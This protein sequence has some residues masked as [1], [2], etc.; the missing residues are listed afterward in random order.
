MTT[1]DISVTLP[2]STVYVS[3]T[4]N[5]VDKTFTLT[6]TLDSSTIWTAEVDRV[7]SD[8]YVCSITA[9]SSNGS[10]T[11]IETTLYYGI[12]NLITVIVAVRIIKNQQPDVIYVETDESEENRD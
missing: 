10:S 3:G 5:G 2:S 7:Q 11:T 12:L 4:V 1:R 9:I 8:I 6:G